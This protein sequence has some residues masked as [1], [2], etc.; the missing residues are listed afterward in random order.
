MGEEDSGTQ[1]GGPSGSQPRSLIVFCDLVG[2]TELSGRH[3]PE[4]Y[5]LLVRRYLA[6]IHQTVEEFDGEVVS[7]EG[8]GLLAS[9]GAPRARGDDAERAVRASL[10]IVERIRDLSVETEREMG[11][12][13]A[14]RVAIHRGQVFRAIDGSIY[15]LAT[16][17]AARLQ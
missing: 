14:V 2:S 12:E 4:R 10:L 9:F 13:L 16:N 15:G 11:E 5:G 17:V 6:E 7:K 3:D 1:A 8:D